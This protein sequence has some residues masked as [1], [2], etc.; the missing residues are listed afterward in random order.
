[1]RSR[2]ILLEMNHHALGPTIDR[3]RQLR[4]DYIRNITW[5][6]MGVTVDVSVT[7]DGGCPMI[8]GVLGNV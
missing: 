3:K 5:Q 1:M 7:R 6:A 2:L 4:R 8:N